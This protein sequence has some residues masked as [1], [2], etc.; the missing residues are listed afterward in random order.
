VKWKNDLI[1]NKTVSEITTDVYEEK[2]NELRENVVNIR[3]ESGLK[4]A[5]MLK[6][7]PLWVFSGALIFLG[8]VCI[9]TA[10]ALRITWHEYRENFWYGNY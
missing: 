6:T 4:R 2:M 10:F 1:A 5:L 9:V 3:S 8:T 7:R